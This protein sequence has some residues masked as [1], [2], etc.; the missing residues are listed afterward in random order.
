[1]HWF[2]KFWIVAA[3]IPFWGAVVAVLIHR[4]QSDSKL[5]SSATQHGSKT[6]AGKHW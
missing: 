1:V 6:H 5:E 2:V 3:L 4:L